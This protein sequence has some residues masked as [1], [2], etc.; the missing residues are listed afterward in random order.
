MLLVIAWLQK[1]SAQTPTT[2]KLLR[3]LLSNQRQSSFQNNIKKAILSP[4]HFQYSFHHS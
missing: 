2:A 1:P 3:R 4:R